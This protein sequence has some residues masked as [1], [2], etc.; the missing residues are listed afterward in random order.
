MLPGRSSAVSY[1]F[2]RIRGA[3]DSQQHDGAG[4]AHRR[5]QERLWRRR[6]GTQGRAA[7]RVGTPEV[8][9]R[10][11]R[12]APARVSLL[13][14]RLSRQRGGARSRRADAGGIRAPRRPPAASRGSGRHGDR[15]HGDPLRVLL[16]HGAVARAALARSSDHRLEGVRQEVERRSRRPAAPAPPVLGNSHGRCR[17]F[18]AP[19]A[20]RRPQGAVRN[21]CGVSGPP[22]RS[23]P[24]AAR[25]AGKRCTSASAFRSSCRRARARRRAPSRSTGRLR[26]RSRHARSIGRARTCS[27]RSGSRRRPSD[28]PRPARPTISSRSRARRW[29]PGRATSTTSST[30][31]GTTSGSSS[32]R[33]ASRSPATASRRSAGFC[34][35]RCTGC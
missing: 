3:R 11:R 6:R 35:N 30:P 31:T 23:D 34:W 13:S 4:P 12:R 17:R 27:T 2:R 5:T 26:P 9:R 1:G 32:T 25:S 20:A 7:P 18:P 10:R 16:V 19:A 24:P 8:A 33:T 22:V 21:R 29:S 14:A 28:R 15:R